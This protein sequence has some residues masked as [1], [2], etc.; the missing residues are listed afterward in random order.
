MF[1]SGEKTEPWQEV[2][3]MGWGNQVASSCVHSLL[4]EPACVIWA[5]LNLST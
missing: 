5:G 2:R 1:A 3:E 4:L